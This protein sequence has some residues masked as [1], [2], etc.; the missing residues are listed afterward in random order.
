MLLSFHKSKNN[1]E[2]RGKGIRND[3]G[4]RSDEGDKRSPPRATAGGYERR[5]GVLKKGGSFELHTA[6]DFG[7]GG[8]T[9]I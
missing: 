2:R 5:K 7:F 3:R 6:K 9:L 8:S 1:K 4:R